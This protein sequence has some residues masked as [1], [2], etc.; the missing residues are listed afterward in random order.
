MSPATGHVTFIWSIAERLRGAYKQSEY[1]R[2]I[3]PFTLLRRLDQVLEPTKDKVLAEAAKLRGSRPEPRRHPQEGR[4]AALLQR[5]QAHAGEGP[6]RP[7]ERRD[8][9]ARVHRRVRQ[10]RPRNLRGVRV[11][12]ADNQGSRRPVGCTASSAASST[13]SSTSSRTPSRT[14]GWATSSRSP[15]GSSPRFP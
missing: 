9:P 8:A 7:R 6:Q 1:G 11:R 15:S 3:L 5:L 4:R 14:T 10:G 13:T 2:V 12:R